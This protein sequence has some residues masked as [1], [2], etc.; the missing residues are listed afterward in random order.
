MRILLFDPV[1]G[2]AG[3]M[4]LAALFDLGVDPKLVEEKLNATGLGNFRLKFQRRNVDQGFQCG[5]CEVE[6]TG[7]AGGGN[8]TSGHQ[9]H[10]H[11]SLSTY[12]QIK[13]LLDQADLTDCTRQRAIQIFSRL[14]DAE[15]QV[16]GCSKEEIHFHE[17]GAADAIADIVGACIA[18]ELLEIDR[19]ECTGYK[20]GQGTVSCQHGVIPVP[21]PATEKLLQQRP[22]SC[23][24]IEQE[25]TTPTGAAVVTTLSQYDGPAPCG[26]RRFVK[27]GIGHGKTELAERPNILRVRLMEV[28]PESRTEGEDETEGV[29]VLE[30]EIDDETPEVLA[31]LCE[32]MLAAGA[33]DA[34]LLPATMKKGRPG[35]RVSVI[36]ESGDGK[37]LADIILQETSTIGVRITQARRHILKRTSTT[38]QTPWGDV[39]AKAVERPHGWEIVP[40]YESCVRVAEEEG[41]PLRD[42]MSAA[43]EPPGAKAPRQRDGR[44]QT[45]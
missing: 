33:L 1:T 36:A 2:L 23:L 44:R 9:H 25:L 37:R 8:Q 32:H 6:G 3:D 19:I 14:A 12:D 34:H 24:G 45:Y 42:V 7:A 17:V 26:Q 18:I 30:S 15:A 16:H 39:Q 21:A 38:A 10:G 35:V 40:E 31:N 5:F 22:V 11:G 29:E 20:V 13:Q 4:I 41:V 27:S 28:D 43:S